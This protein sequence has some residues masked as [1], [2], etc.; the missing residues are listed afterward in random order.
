MTLWAIE[1]LFGL[2]RKPWYRG[3][4]EKYESHDSLNVHLKDCALALVVMGLVYLLAGESGLVLLVYV[5]AVIVVIL[6][7]LST[8]IS[9]GDF[10]DDDDFYH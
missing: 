9:H 8:A 4:V 5:Y 6:L 2:R 1:L 10:G 3:L 7:L